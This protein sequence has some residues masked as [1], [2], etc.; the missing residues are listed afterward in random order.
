MSKRLILLFLPVA[1]EAHG[2][3]LTSPGEMGD[4]GPAAQLVSKELS[5][6]F[7]EAA[8]TVGDRLIHS[9]TA[10]SVAATVDGKPILIHDGLA[11][12]SW[13]PNPSALHAAR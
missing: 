12:A 5:R 10:V 9:P 3:C 4:I 11:A 2:T 1:M 13:T 7:P 8:L 6:Q